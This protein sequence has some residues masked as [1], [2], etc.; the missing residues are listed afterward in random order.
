MLGIWDFIILIHNLIIKLTSTIT[1]FIYI[2]LPYKSNKYST[3][4]F[5]SQTFNY[6][7]ISKI[8]I[9][10]AIFISEFFLRSVCAHH[11][12]ISS[13]SVANICIQIIIVLIVAVSS[14]WV[15]RN[16][17]GFNFV[18][19]TIWFMWTII[20]YWFSLFLWSFLDRSSLKLCIIFG[21]ILGKS[22]IIFV[23]VFKN[24]LKILL[25][26]ILFLHILSDLCISFIFAQFIVQFLINLY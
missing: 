24:W 17:L 14:F 10:A 6:S 21:N 25:W 15:L 20:D 8:V 4:L 26:C 23:W 18:I 5:S 7:F 16:W 2:S 19:G 1:L 22:T 3:L 11:H 9:A 13:S 12:C